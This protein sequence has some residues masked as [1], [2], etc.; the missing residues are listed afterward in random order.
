MSKHFNINLVL[1]STPKQVENAEK[2]LKS[3]KSVKRS[4]SES[5]GNKS[6]TGFKHIK[7]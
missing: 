2:D 5:V 4:E 1:S 6:K 7:Q 3:E